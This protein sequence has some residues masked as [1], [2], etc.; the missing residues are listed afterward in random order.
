MKI[1]DFLFYCLYRI[2]KLI[3]RQGVKD[4]DLASLLYFVLLA[5]NTSTILLFLRDAFPK[6]F[7]KSH[8]LLVKLIFIMPF[9]IWYFFCKY[10][11]SKKQ[12]DQRIV[13][14]FEQK[15]ITKNNQMVTIGIIYTLLSFFL[16]ISIAMLLSR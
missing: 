13:N 4:E 16:F 6:D 9:F 12:N 1:F 5:T 14:T 10:Y 2:F 7:F 8:M 11:F 3:P 15:Y